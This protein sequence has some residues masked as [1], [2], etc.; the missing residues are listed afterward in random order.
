MLNKRH[1]SLLTA[2]TGAL[3]LITGIFLT[4]GVPGRPATPHAAKGV[5]WSAD[6]VNEKPPAEVRQVANWIVR[7]QD[8]GKQGFI[9]LDKMNTRLY[10]F[11]EGGVLRAASP[12]LI[13][14][15]VGDDSAPG[16]GTRPLN[17]VKAQEKTTPAGRF[18][19]ERGH[20]NKGDD[21][22]WVDYDAAI[23]MHRVIDT[24]PA[25]HRLQRL[26]SPTTT[27]N[28]ISFGC[29]NVPPAFYNTYI[30]PMFAVHRANVYILPD[31][32]S[33]QQVFN[34]S[35]DSMTAGAASRREPT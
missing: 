31:T 25:E 24:G 28:R 11:A 20:D 6:F 10:V 23:S 35:A 26:A 19:G 16:I 21:L 32:R 9:L 27:D 13:G 33:V 22:V 7:S 8:A 4:M 3:A 15:A 12:V 34:L 29:I 2:V 18:I 30:S 17:Q 1:A 14:A 5:E